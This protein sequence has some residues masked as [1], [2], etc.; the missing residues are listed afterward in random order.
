MTTITPLLP[1]PGNHNKNPKSQDHMDPRIKSCFPGYPKSKCNKKGIPG[2]SVKTQKKPRDIKFYDEHGSPVTYRIQL[3]DNPSDPCND[4]YLIH[5]QQRN[6][7]NVLRLHYDGENFTLNSLNNEFPSTT[8]Q[9]VTDCFR[10]GK[11]INH[12]RHLCYLQYNP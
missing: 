5:G 7:N 10:L 12:F 11:T 8:I 1:I 9:S 4:F 3:D 6:D 2:A